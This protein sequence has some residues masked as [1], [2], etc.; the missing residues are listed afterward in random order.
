L[1]LRQNIE[2]CSQVACVSHIDRMTVLLSPNCPTYFMHCHA[3]VAKWHA[4]TAS[5]VWRQ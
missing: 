1:V 4:T 2:F 3:L 5:A